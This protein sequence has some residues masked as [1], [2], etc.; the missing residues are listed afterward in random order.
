MDIPETVA[1]C[2]AEGGVGSYSFQIQNDSNRTHGAVSV[3]LGDKSFIEAGDWA[4]Q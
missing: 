4:P 1:L 2:L 3:L